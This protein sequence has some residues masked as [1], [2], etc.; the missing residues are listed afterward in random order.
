MFLYKDKMLPEKKELRIALQTIYGVGFNK[1]NLIVNK[2]GIK[3]PYSIDNLNTYKINLILFLLK[4]LV[5]SETKIN[6]IIEFNIQKIIQNSSYRGKR[7]LMC[8]PVR[9]QRTKSNAKTQK[10][11]RIKPVINEEGR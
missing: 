1:A 6:R 9:G 5:K 10:R 3:Y 4:G 2:I 8:L 11:K 7:H